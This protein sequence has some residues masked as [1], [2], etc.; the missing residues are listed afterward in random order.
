MLHKR[1]GHFLPKIQFYSQSGAGWVP[2]RLS[3]QPEA[4]NR[5]RQPGTF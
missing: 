4:R 5:F 1:W 2:S 3:I